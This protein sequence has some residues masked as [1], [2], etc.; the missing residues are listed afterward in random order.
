VRR[1]FDKKSGFTLIEL[2]VVVAII[3]ILA[4]L[5]LPALMR[6]KAEGQ[7]SSCKNHLRQIGLAMG[8]Y[9]ADYHRYPLM[10]G[11]H[12]GVSQIWA[13]RL[14]P[15]GVLKWTNA[16][17][18]CPS[19]VA[20]DGVIKLTRMGREYF[21]HGSYGFNGYGVA[22]INDVTNSSKLGLGN[23]RASSIASESEL[24]A[25]SEMFAVADGRT[26][27]DIWDSGEGK[28]P[29]LS[30]F[31][32]LQLYYTIREETSPLH[33]KGYNMLFTDGH[34]MMVKHADL[35]FPPRTAQHWNR[36]NQPHPEV[37]APRNQWAVQ[38]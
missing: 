6:A 17:W 30:S 28:A 21:V 16:A 15:Y 26:Y 20:K 4:A 27:R 23:T 18:H 3:A 29:G 25:P 5:L 14:E 34:V 9:V 38:N 22:R 37:W 31:I 7:S 33:V 13:D 12:D 2:L 11:Q 32:E 19:Y 24:R 36:D 1:V 10:W 8:M 35:L